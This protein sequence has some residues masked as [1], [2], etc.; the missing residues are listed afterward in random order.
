[1][2]PMFIHPHTFWCPINLDAP[3]MFRVLIGYL[4]CYI[5]KCFPTLEAVLR[6]VRL[7][8]C[9]Y[10]PMFICPHIF[11]HLCM[12]GCPHMFWCLLYD[13]CSICLHTPYMYGHSPYVWLPSI[14]LDVPHVFGCLAIC[15]D[16]PCMCGHPQMYGP[17]KVWGH[18]NIW[19]YPNMEH[20]N[21]W[22]SKHIGASKDK[23]GSQT[24]GGVQTYRGHQNIEGASKHGRCPKR[25]HPN[26]LGVT[27]HMGASKDPGAYGHPLS[28]TTPPRLPLK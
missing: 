8:G 5:I 16:S 1:M 26:I 14:C 4:F 7:R 12:F 17:P 28:L 3:H 9:P 22:V 23:E 2:A 25:G 13:G 18:S 6:V 21:I 15:L 19:G 24:Y 20:P 27:K 11:R 10:T